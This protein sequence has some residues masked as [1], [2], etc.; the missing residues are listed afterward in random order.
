MV[1]LAVRSRPSA[2]DLTERN[3]IKFISSINEV[4]LDAVYSETFMYDLEDVK[5]FQKIKVK[6]PSIKREK[7]TIEV[8][9][10]I[11][12]DKDIIETKVILR[13]KKIVSYNEKHIGTVCS[14]YGPFQW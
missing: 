11:A 9:Y 13:G 3:F 10:F 6:L 14:W 12:K 1:L 8:S 5:E 2:Y 7:E 4:L